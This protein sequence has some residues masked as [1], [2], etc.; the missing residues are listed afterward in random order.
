MSN[1]SRIIEIPLVYKASFMP[2]RARNAKEVYIKETV[3]IALRI[4][5]DDEAPLSFKVHPHA[6][7]AQGITPLPVRTTGEVHWLPILRGYSGDDHAVDAETV[8]AELK[9]GRRSINRPGL[10][11]WATDNAVSVDSLG[12]GK[13][14]SSTRDWAVEEAQRQAGEMLL[15]GNHVFVP[16]GEPVYCRKS[17]GANEYFSATNTRAVT[18]TAGADEI[19]PA[20]RLDLIV[21]ALRRSGAS[22]AELSDPIASERIWNAIEV[23]R[24]DLVRYRHNEEPRLRKAADALVT[25]ARETIRRTIDTTSP[26]LLEAFHNLRNDVAAGLPAADLAMSMAVFRRFIDQGPWADIAKRLD[27]NLSDWER[28]TADLAD[29]DM[30]GRAL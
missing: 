27:E 18:D 12:P 17:M 15:C 19:I 5:S 13:F 2:K 10:Y 11:D 3:P 21:E 1:P 14:M 8:I 23:L 26:E 24:P 20:N 6:Y 29:E 9:A 22:A 30:L 16:C 28:F 25:V 4:A 7:G